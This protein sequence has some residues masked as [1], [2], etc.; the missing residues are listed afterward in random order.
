MIFGIGNPGKK[1]ENT[2]HN[3]GFQILDKLAEKHKLTFKAENKEY[4]STGSIINASR[5]LLVKPVTYVNLSGVAAKEVIEKYN[6][7]ISEFLV[8]TDDLNL[9]LGK[10]RIRRSGGDGGHNGL[11]S[12]IFAYNLFTSSH[13]KPPLC[14]Q[15]NSTMLLQPN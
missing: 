8:I 11:H 2:K 10:I 6:V 15:K 13:V 7:P 4:Y 1:Y 14:T 12:I 3:I 9:E 5:F